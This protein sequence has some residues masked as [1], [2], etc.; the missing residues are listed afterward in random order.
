MERSDP[1]FC[2]GFPGCE[3]S[4]VGCKA[5]GVTTVGG[6]DVEGRVMDGVMT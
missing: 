2:D 4:T 1:R 6:R 3:A 5:G